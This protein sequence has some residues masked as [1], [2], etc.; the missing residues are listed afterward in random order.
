MNTTVMFSSKTDEW[1]TPQD[2]FDELDREFNFTLDPCA[3]PQNAKCKKYYTKAEDG[4]KQ[5]WQGEVVFCNPP[6]GREI[7][8]WVK[9]CY[10][11]SKKPDTTVVMLIPARTD[12]NYFHDYIYGKAKEIRFIRGRLK[13]GKSKNAAPF[14][15]MVVVF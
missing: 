9:K 6:Y 5:D 10:E 8:K 1:E 7:S 4:L 2:F 11:E 15:S 13:F 3:T 12:T 14:P